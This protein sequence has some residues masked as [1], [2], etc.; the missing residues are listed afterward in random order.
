MGGNNRN[1]RNLPES[2]DVQLSILSNSSFCLFVVF[3]LFVF[4]SP[5]HIK[6]LPKM[7]PLSTDSFSSKK[8]VLVMFSVRLKVS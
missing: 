2:Y 4:N 5:S 3:C 8:I 6:L 1:E 7:V